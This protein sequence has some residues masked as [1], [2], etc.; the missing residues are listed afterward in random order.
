MGSAGLPSAKDRNNGSAI[1]ALRAPMSSWARSTSPKFRTGNEL[2]LHVRIA[3]TK[4]D[5]DLNERGPLRFTIV[6]DGYKG[7][8]IVPEGKAEPRWKTLRLTFER[9]R[10]CYF[11]IVDHS[12]EG[13][14][15]VDE[16]VFSGF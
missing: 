6:A 10:I 12:R 15:A 16:I 4:G 9:K 13:H 3:G 8:H 1:L 7:Q 11:E 5:Q 2:F 14:I